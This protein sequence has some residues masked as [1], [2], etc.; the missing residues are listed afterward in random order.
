MNPDQAKQLQLGV[1]DA[2]SAVAEN[3]QTPHPFPVGR[4]F[5]QSLGYP[6]EL[7]AQLPAAAVDAFTGLSNVSILAELSPGST[8]LDLGCGAGLDSLIA[9]QRVGPSGRVI[10]LDFSQAML[11]RARQAARESG[12]AQVTLAQSTAETLA[13]AEAS[14]DIALV[15]GIFN[16]NPARERIFQELARVMRSGGIIYA[17]EIVLTEAL[18]ADNAPS[19]ANWFA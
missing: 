9:A 2:Y 5:A 18:P 10:G 14:L 1:H 12:L 6:V 11:Q 16:L 13:L 7:L 19:E 17:T 4:E 8:V 3:P 15:N